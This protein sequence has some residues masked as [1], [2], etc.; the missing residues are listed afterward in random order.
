MRGIT[1]AIDDHMKRKKAVGGRLGKLGF[2]DFFSFLVFLSLISDEAA[3]FFSVGFFT[4][5]V[6]FSTTCASNQRQRIK[7]KGVTKEFKRN[8]RQG[9]GLIPRFILILE[10]R[11]QLC[12]SINTTGTSLLHPSLKSKPKSPE[13]SR[14]PRRTKEYLEKERKEYHRVKALPSLARLRELVVSASTLFL[15]LGGFD[16]REEAPAI[17]ED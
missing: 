15:C 16:D 12:M 1:R 10:S 13:I 3:L 11:L 6:A 7:N 4:T 8:Q 14:K 9:K 2:L 5:S 17:A